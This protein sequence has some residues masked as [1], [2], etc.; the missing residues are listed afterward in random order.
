MNS[1]LTGAG[2][3]ESEAVQKNALPFSPISSDMKT[4]VVQHVPRINERER[5]SEREFQVPSFCLTF[6]QF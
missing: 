4:N 1:K 3:A 6:G 5:E 2:V